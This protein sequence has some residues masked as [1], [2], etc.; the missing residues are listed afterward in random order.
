[1]R[2]WKKK[3]YKEVE[4]K[5][6]VG[7]GRQVV[8]TRYEGFKEIKIFRNCLCCLGRGTQTVLERVE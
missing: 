4:C 6:C 8:N 2:F 7:T 1:M 3:Y 5:A